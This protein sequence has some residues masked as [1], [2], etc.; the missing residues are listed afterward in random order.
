MCAKHITAV[1][2]IKYIGYSVATLKYLSGVYALQAVQ[3]PTMIFDLCSERF[4]SS[5][6]AV[7]LG[8]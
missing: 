6:K 8:N 3:H 5:P 1:A 4:P 7:W 2:D